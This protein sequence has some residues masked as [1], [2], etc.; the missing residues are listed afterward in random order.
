MAER[1]LLSMAIDVNTETTA[2]REI[3]GAYAGLEKLLDHCGTED[4]PELPIERAELHGLLRLMNGG[5]HRQIELMEDTVCT[6]VLALR[7]APPVLVTTP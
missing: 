2:L 5:M 1:T 6:L 4:D 3:L 7:T